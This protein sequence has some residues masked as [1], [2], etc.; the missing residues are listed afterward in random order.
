ML[1]VRGVLF[2]AVFIY[3]V[4]R[5]LRKP[6]YGYFLMLVLLVAKPLLFELIPQ[7]F[8]DLHAPLVLGLFV[9]FCCFIS[10]ALTSLDR[11][12]LV[13]FGFFTLFTLA[14]WLSRIDDPAGITAHKYVGEITNM[15]LLFLIGVA[16]VRTSRD[17][18][19]L[20]LVLM[21]TVTVLAAVSYWH[22]R[23]QGWS[24]PLPSTTY[25]DRN[26]FAL[27]IAAFIPL[28][29]CVVGR[30]G[31]LAPKLLAVVPI[32]LIIVCVIPSYSRGAFLALMAAFLLSV[33]LMRN[34]KVF[35]ITLILALAAG[36]LRVSDSYLARLSSSTD[37]EEE[38]SAAGRI[39]TYEA[40]L[41]MFQSAPLMGVG[42]GNFNDNF[43]ENCPERYRVFCQPGKS[44]HNIYLQVLS[45][46]GLVG[47]TTFLLFLLSVLQPLLRMLLPGKGPK[48]SHE[49]LCYAFG[50]SFLVLL[51]GY[52]LLPGAYDSLIYPFGASF[53]SAQLAKPDEEA[54]PC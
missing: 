37:Y 43:W 14:C 48:T 9:L 15:W 41:A 38:A 32:V 6:K 11:R 33:K 7:I 19:G 31:R 46:T 5:S 8:T 12:A 3:C 28:F 10:G 13:I 4:V 52:L 36:S 35:L 18:R 53:V 24:M 26:E 16:A 2:L 30:A 29:L 22:Y 25:V 42:V 40:A 17:L 20:H 54:P 39:A 23:H 49:K 21:G 34:R 44:V 50:A 1:S 47:M 45:E 51:L 27:T